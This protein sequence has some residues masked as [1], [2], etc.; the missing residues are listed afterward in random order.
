MSDRY[1]HNMHTVYIPFLFTNESN[2]MKLHTFI[3]FFS[4]STSVRDN[5]P[6]I[7]KL[8]KGHKTSKASLPKK[9]ASKYMLKKNTDRQV[10]RSP[11]IINSEQV[12]R[13][14]SLDDINEVAQYNRYRYYSKLTSRLG[15]PLVRTKIILVLAY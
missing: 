3:Y 11:Y 12:H 2:H 6:L 7:N 8:N 14:A 10:N 4:E 9:I 1:V 15:Q 5:S 13:T